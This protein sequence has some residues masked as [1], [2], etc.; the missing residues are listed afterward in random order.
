MDHDTNGNLAAVA[1]AGVPAWHALSF[2]ETAEHLNASP[3][4]G[5]SHEEAARRL[6]IHGRNEIREEGRRS[7]WKILLGQ[8]TDFMIIL[9]ILAAAISGIVGEPEDAIVIL[10]IV[11]LNALIG[12]IQE[13]RAERA[14]QAL[15]KLAA[16]RAKVIRDGH[17]TTIL[18]PELVPG[19][20]VLLEAGSGV[21]ADLRLMEVIQLK[22]EEAALTGESQPVEKS[23]ASLSDR[24]SPLGDRI[25]MAYTGTI[26][27]YGRGRGIAVSTGMRSE[28][29][30]IATLLAATEEPKTP[31]QRRL[32]KFG[33][34]LALAAIGICI[35]VFI[36]GVARGESIL[37]MFLTAV[38]LAVAAVPEALPA[39]VTISLALG[40]QRM[41][42][43][44][45][46]IR[47]LPAVETLGSVTYVCSDKTGTLTENKMRAEAYFI[48]GGILDEVSETVVQQ[49][50]CRLLFSALALNNDANT[51][52]DGRVIG[53]PTEAA[54]YGAA[55]LAG[56][57][58]TALERDM[59]RI[60]ELPFDS[61]RKCMT[62]LH[63]GHTGVVAFTKGAPERVIERCA[64]CL[65][66]AGLGRIDVRSL[67]HQADQMASQGLRVLAVA[68][69]EWPDLPADLSPHF[70]ERDLVFIGLV[71]LIDPPRPEVA[72]AVAECKSAGVTP[73]MITGDHPLTARAI[74]SRVNIINDG[75]LVVTGRQLA[76]MTGDSL[77]EQVN[78]IGVYARVDPEQKIRIVQA[79]QDKGEFVA[80]T[81]D[82]VNDAPALKRADIGVAMGN[83][84][85]DVARE[86]SHMVL[87]DDNFASIVAAVREG[88]RIYD[89][90]RRFVRYA[91][92]GN[93]G[94]IVTIAVA[95]FLGLPLP[96]LPI[97]ILWVNLVTD[98][99]P[100]LALAVE[101]AEK[102]IMQRPP[103]HPRESIFSRGLGIQVVWVGLLIGGLSIF[104]QVWAMGNGSE[105]WQ[106]MVFTTLTF[107]Q[108]FQVMAI[109]S[110]RESLF[111]Q[112]LGSNLPLLGTVVL[113]TALQLVVIYSP[114]LNDLLKT[115]PLS[116]DELA[117]CFFVPSTV[118]AA[119]EAEKW[120]TRKGWSHRHAA[121]QLAERVR[122]S[123]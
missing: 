47:R 88:R 122:C 18:A 52:K 8:F 73:I 76:Q 42:G 50:S 94:E 5:L 111:Q 29:G 93:T 70:V 41:V 20:V 114:F 7:V 65:T 57:D 11:V 49:P 46:L 45:V 35:L 32:A 12:F 53:D 37:L 64:M 44:N 27:T 66:D 81:G 33:K 112:G 97:H 69:R 117:F 91:L 30:K 48:N 54:L 113:T 83:I 101:P 40:A 90:I 99:L 75:G 16:I 61:E 68:H 62:T 92:A 25:N 13:Y 95:P 100:G 104:T 36:G 2:E 84:G 80:M 77:A 28:L 119:I 38:A 103:R 118:F 15:R 85:T 58:K 6:S 105:N 110:D 56:Y 51:D 109:R 10:A 22:I 108:L 9:L 4:L 87:L 63:R 67:I 72:A 55:R 71:G 78:D 34:Q 26:V 79:L 98:G 39:V 96:L 86:A 31:L 102:G 19:D 107:A 121:S 115:R 89:N 82:G 116:L 60:A 106:T 17:I 23:T 14:L 123:R 24:E 59:P 3:N 21:P 74:A 120:L 1:N 43:K